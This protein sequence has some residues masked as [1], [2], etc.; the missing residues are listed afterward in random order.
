MAR[1]PL[2]TRVDMAH[3]S[4]YSK[5]RA[6]GVG[7]IVIHHACAT[8]IESVANTF[9]RAGRNGSAHYTVCGNQISL[10]VDEAD[11]AWHCSNLWG[12]NR[13]IGIETCNSTLAPDYKVA[14]D[15][16]E[17]LA[18]LVADIAKRYGLG[19]LY[20]NP[21]EDLPKLSGHKDWYGASTSCP[22]P[23]LYPRLQWLCDRAN[24]IN[25]PPAPAKP[26]LTWSKLPEITLYKTRL[27]PT[28]LW[29]VNC[30]TFDAVKSMEQF[31]KGEIVEVAGKVVNKELDN[32]Y[33]IT[34]YY[35][36]HKEAIG[37]NQGD[38][39]LVP[40]APKFVWEDLPEKTGF[41][42]S[43][44][45]NLWNLDDGKVVQTY[46]ANTKIDVVQFTTVDGEKYY[47]TDYSKSKNFNWAFKVGD[48]AP[49]ISEPMPIP[50]PEPSAPSPSTPSNSNIDTSQ[51]NEK[52]SKTKD[53][54]QQDGS[55]SS[56][57]T[58]AVLTVLNAIVA[59]IKKIINLI[60]GKDK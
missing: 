24:A 1:S 36:N 9:K 45:C 7:G 6:A 51:E 34:P 46:S 27:Q 28:H 17:T 50:E 25:Y 56:S 44:A 23:Y 57:D 16:M 49:I 4:N 12:N 21:S 32:T 47:R 15:T 40:P 52:D 37:F 3:P 10:M 38:M 11:T 59:F 39:E 43:C 18:R 13:T 42:T 29:N 2:T 41:F 53:E 54:P 58:K 31:N 8:T 14:D 33:L 35:F 60:I 22:G 55:D 20:I 19:K 5:G 48:L 30:T 26:T